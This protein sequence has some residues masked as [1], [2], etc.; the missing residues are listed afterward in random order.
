M[1]AITLHRIRHGWKRADA[2]K[3]VVSERCS[4]IRSISANGSAQP[5]VTSRMLMVAALNA[6]RHSAGRLVIPNRLDGQGI[7]QLKRRMPP[8][9][10]DSGALTYSAKRSVEYLYDY[11]CNLKLGGCPARCVQA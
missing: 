7:Q 11:S 4:L 3:A 8:G 1:G 2:W 5:C 9:P 10:F 6:I